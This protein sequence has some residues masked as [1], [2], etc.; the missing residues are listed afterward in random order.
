[1]SWQ[2]FVGNEVLDQLYDLETLPGAKL[3]ERAQQAKAFDGVARGRTKPQMQFSGE[4]EVLHLATTT[5]NPPFPPLMPDARTTFIPQENQ[6]RKPKLQGCNYAKEQLSEQAR[7]VALR[8]GH[9][10]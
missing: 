6:I 4:I 10:G 7:P 5:L 9:F 3:E 2:S 1:M 8:H